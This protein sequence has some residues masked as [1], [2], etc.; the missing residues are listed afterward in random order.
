MA[1]QREFDEDK[2]LNAL[3][4]VFWEYGYEGTSYADIMAATGLKKGSLYAAFGDKRALYQKAIERYDT[5]IVSAG[6]KMLRNETLSPK[7]R[8][9]NFMNGPVEAAG[10]A[11]GR[12]G[13]LLC[14][15]AIDQ[16]PMDKDAESSITASINR[17]KDAIA[18]AVGDSVKADIILTAYFGAHVLVKAGMP[19]EMLETIRDE[20]VRQV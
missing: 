18:F 12:R 2:V 19:R 1:R 7:T 5:E 4:D 14:N 20:T 10:S 9:E 6:V 15:V 8:I 13:C 11:K 3:R 16:A 17:L